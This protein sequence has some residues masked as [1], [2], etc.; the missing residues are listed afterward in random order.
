MDDLA[1]K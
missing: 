1:G